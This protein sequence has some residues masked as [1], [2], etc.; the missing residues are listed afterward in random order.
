MKE[1][2]LEAVIIYFVIGTIFVLM[3]TIGTPRGRLN[4]TMKS[5]RTGE[6]LDERRTRIFM[7]SLCLYWPFLVILLIKSWLKG[8]LTR[9]DEED[10]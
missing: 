3:F 2:I 9:D 1:A 7:L 8:G 10:E 5:K 6:I 4:L